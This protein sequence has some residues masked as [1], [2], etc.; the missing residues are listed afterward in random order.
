MAETTAVPPPVVPSAHGVP[1]ADFNDNEI[2]LKEEEPSKAVTIIKAATIA[3][4]A[5]TAKE[6]KAAGTAAS[7]PASKLHSAPV[8]SSHFDPTALHQRTI[9]LL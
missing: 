7:M 2:S 5:V 4:E 1:E 9:S 6:A 3:K 8:R